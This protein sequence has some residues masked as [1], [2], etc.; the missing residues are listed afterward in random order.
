[1]LVPVSRRHLRD[2]TNVVE[3][4]EN[5]AVEHEVPKKDVQEVERLKQ[6]IAD[7]SPVEKHANIGEGPWWFGLKRIAADR[8]AFE[9][10]EGAI[11][12]GEAGPIKKMEQKVIM[13]NATLLRRIEKHFP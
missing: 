4:S 12:D 1:M 2:K 5:S 11:T 8:A 3:S 9:G 10:K 6:E 13:E 7:R